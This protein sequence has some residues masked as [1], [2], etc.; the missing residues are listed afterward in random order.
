ML[1]QITAAQPSP[2]PTFFVNLDATVLNQGIEFALDYDIIDQEDL[3]W[4][5][6]FNIS[7]NE[8][9]LQDF[10]GAIPAGTIYG[11]GLS[12]AFSQILAVGHPI[13]SYI[14]REF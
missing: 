5:A 7:Y 6:N 11:Q 10:G 4:N 3:T 2:Q 13:F 8:N 14:L 1:L 9:E 12:F